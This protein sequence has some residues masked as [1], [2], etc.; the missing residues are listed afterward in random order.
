MKRQK[1]DRSSNDT[2]P[3][4]YPIWETSIRKTLTAKQYEL[5]E[6]EKTRRQIVHERAATDAF[7]AKADQELFLNPDQR[8]KLADWICQEYGK[9]L[10]D[11][12]EHKGPIMGQD[13]ANAPDA[14]SPPEEVT[15]VLTPA[16]LQVWKLVCARQLIQFDQ[17]RKMR[18]MQMPVPLLAPAAPIDD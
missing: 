11:T 14:L 6:R 18:P 12:M 4:D 16:Q 5:Y 17:N 7:V 1:I 15:S 13:R 10:L 2:N 3:E 9:D 8:E